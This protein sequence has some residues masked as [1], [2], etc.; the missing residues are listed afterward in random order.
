[1]AVSDISTSGSLLVPALLIMM[2]IKFFVVVSYFM[3]LKYDNRLFRFGFYIGLCRRGVPV[4][5]D[6]PTFHFFID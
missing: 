3:H 4:L 5:G 6:A 1:M 2:A